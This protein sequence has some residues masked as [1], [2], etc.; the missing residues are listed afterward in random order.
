M[1]HLTQRLELRCDSV[2]TH[3]T[4]KLPESVTGPRR[5]SFEPANRR[6]GRGFRLAISDPQVGQA[7]RQ[8]HNLRRCSRQDLRPTVRL[9]HDVEARHHLVVF[10]LQVVAVKNECAQIVFK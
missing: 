3:I 8:L 5:T 4:A 6:D 1:W 2:F 10:M 7:G 9:R